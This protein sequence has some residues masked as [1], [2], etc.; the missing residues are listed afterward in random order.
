MRKFE[1]KRVEGR[2]FSEENLNSFGSEGWELCSH[3]MI[4]D[5]VGWGQRFEYIFKREIPE[6]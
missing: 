5:T 1:Y 4:S 3:T 2:N 6:Q